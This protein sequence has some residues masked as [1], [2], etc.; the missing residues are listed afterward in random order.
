MGSA[1]TSIEDDIVSAS[2]NPATLNLYQVKK[3]YRLTIY[4]NPIAPTTLYYEQFNNN[5]NGENDRG[6]QKFFKT[7]SL[8]MK[9]LVFTGKF[10][11]MALIFHEQTL[12]DKYLL[13]Q[14]K[15][16]KNCDIWENSYHTLITSL[17]LADRVAVGAA[18]SIYVKRINDHVQQGIGFSYGILLK[19]ANNMNVGMSFIDFPQSMPEVRL[20]L[21][22]MVDQTMNIGISYQPLTST[23]ISFDL[24]NLTE[25]QR[26]SVREAHLGLEQRIFS[27]FAIRGGYFQERF[28]DNRTFSGGVA[29][30]DSNL[31][32][33]KDN[34]FKHTQFMVNYS[35][36]H[37]KKDNQILKWHILSLLIRI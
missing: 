6:T 25:E 18:G 11:D 1:Y 28:T 35:F 29:L 16:F 19:P 20:P 7:A 8:L 12:D 14:K 33:S 9:G 34:R 32:F 22:R 15:F 31:L 26:K 5:Q 37:Q 36:V 23:T 21:E 3:D 27:I 30:F 2:Y 17:K 13:Q 24:R 10:F 4:L